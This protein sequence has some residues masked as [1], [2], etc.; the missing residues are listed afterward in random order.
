MELLDMPSESVAMV[1]EASV[2]V[3]GLDQAMKLRIV[4]TR[5]LVDT[6]RKHFSSKA[7]GETVDY[8]IKEQQAYKERRVE[9]ISS[10][11]VAAVRSYGRHV[12]DFVNPGHSMIHYRE[13]KADNLKDYALAAAAFLNLKPLVRKLVQDGASHGYSTC[14]GANW[15]LI[16]F[17]T[18][19][20][21][22]S[23]FPDFDVAAKKGHEHIVRPAL[24]NRADPNTCQCNHHLVLV[25]AN[26]TAVIATARRGHEG[27]VR[28]LVSRGAA[29]NNLSPRLAQ[30]VS[31]PLTET[32]KGG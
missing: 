24:D 17:L 25:M 18:G 15:P 29:I 1:I 11:C 7:I 10:L 9:F 22:G 13:L 6:R 4:C 12:Y 27:V 28:L 8:I 16:R 30:W 21:H 14:F 3:N 23:G 20:I 26:A 5:T 31:P 32:V 19:L 2:V